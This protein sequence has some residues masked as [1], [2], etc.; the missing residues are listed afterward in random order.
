MSEKSEKAEK[1]KDALK[2]THQFRAG[3]GMVYDLKGDGNRLT[4]RVFPRQNPSDLDE[5][6]IEAR[7]SEAP[8]AAVV[9][10]WGKTRTEALAAVGRSWVS[11]A[12]ARS[13]PTFDWDAVAEALS[14]VRAI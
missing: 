3:I 4:V 13:L 14:A 12:S 9:S 8:E 7:S 1:N 2:I 5:W 10:E 6:R 11:E